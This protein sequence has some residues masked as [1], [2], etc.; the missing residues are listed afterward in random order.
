ML[1][2][3]LNRRKEEDELKEA[4]RL[5]PGQSLTKKFPLIGHRTMV[6]YADD[7]YDKPI[8]LTN[9]ELMAVLWDTDPSIRKRTS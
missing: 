5:P 7:F 8:F 9:P 6:E 2:N 3:I 1:N 4:G